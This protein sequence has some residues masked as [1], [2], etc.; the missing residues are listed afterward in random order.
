MSFQQT[1]TCSEI[2]EYV[3][4]YKQKHGVSCFSGGASRY[5]PVNQGGEEHFPCLK[6][7]MSSNGPFSI[8]NVSVLEYIHAIPCL[9]AKSMSL[10]V[11]LLSN[12]AGLVY[13]RL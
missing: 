4:L 5:P 2:S 1:N 9:G 13:I 10:H 6:G 11:A 3:N 8:A 7:N 12:I